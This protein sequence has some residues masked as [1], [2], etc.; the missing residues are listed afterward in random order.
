[1]PRLPAIR[2]KIP[3][4]QKPTPERRV[5]LNKERVSVNAFVV[6]GLIKRRGELAGDIEKAHEALRKMVLD[7]ENLMF[8]PN[9]N[10]CSA[11]SLQG[12]TVAVA[13]WPRADVHN[14]G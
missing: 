2:A 9:F 12:L 11:G 8:R 5:C 14:R 7:L 10:F 13:R 6:S 1:M 3:L 4:G